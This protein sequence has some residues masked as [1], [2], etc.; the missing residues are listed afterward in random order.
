MRG[1]RLRN[2][3]GMEIQIEKNMEKDMESWAYKGGSRDYARLGAQ[4]PANA[5][6]TST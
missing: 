5:M 6:S 1:S 3:P 4:L 2:I